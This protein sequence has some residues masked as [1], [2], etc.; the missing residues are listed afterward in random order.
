[1]SLARRDVSEVT[2]SERAPE[3]LNM[4]VTQ[5]VDFHVRDRL[6]VSIQMVT[7]DDEPSILKPLAGLC[8]SSQR[9][10]SASAA[11]ALRAEARQGADGDDVDHHGV[12]A[13]APDRGAVGHASYARVP[14]SEWA[15]VAVD[16]VNDQHRMGL[17]AALL[18][19][20]A[21]FAESHH[22]TRVFA[23]VLPE[24]RDMLTLFRDTFGATTVRHSG[25]VDVLFDTSSW[26]RAA[27]QGRD[28]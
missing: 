8:A 15:E 20:L 10:R 18:I 4:S 1:M 2:G 27:Q 28:R 13:T 22:I 17:A 23:E 7:S 11:V 14:G 12:L 6:D 26:R 24:N 9:L 21:Q 25:G 16:V 3:L 19:R 5:L